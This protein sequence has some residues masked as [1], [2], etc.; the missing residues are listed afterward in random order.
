MT[1]LQSAAL[2]RAGSPELSERQAAAVR[3]KGGPLLVLGGPGTGKTHVLERRWL[4]LAGSGS[5]RPHQVLLLC[6]NRAY[7]LEA[8]DRLVWALP[9]P[10]T[11]EV[12]VYTWH[13]LAYHLVARHYPRLGYREPPVLLTGPEQW[14]LVRELLAAEHPAD[15]PRWAERLT[16]RGFVDEVADFC[17]RVGQRLMADEDL[18]A[19]ARHRPDWL[20]VVR[21]RSR[22]REYLRTESRLDYAGLIETAVDLLDGNPDIRGALCRRF[23]HVL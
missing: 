15:W 4:A 1:A 13:A 5:L 6:T 10:A 23:P 12:P 14:G 20:E 9:D 17:L 8:R 11:I 19:L 21:F 3:H 16:D 2:C 22:Y 18:E 7:A